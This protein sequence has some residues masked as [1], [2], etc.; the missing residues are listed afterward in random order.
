LVNHYKLDQGARLHFIKAAVHR[1]ITQGS[2]MK[3]L[4]I[5]SCRC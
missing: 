3:A 4:E 2:N 1:K 5:V